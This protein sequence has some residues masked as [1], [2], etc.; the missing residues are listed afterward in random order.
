[1]EEHKEVATHAQSYYSRGR[2]GQDNNTVYAG[3]AIL[4][5]LVLGLGAFTF[6]ELSNI[7][8]QLSKSSD[9]ESR[10]KMLERNAITATPQPA[11][12]TPTAS[13]PTQPVENII[14][15]YDSSCKTCADA[16]SDVEAV[17]AQSIANGL[18]FTAID[19]SG[20]VVGMTASGFK[21]L[22]AVYFSDANAKNP[23]IS[24]L[25][26]QLQN[27][28]LGNAVQGGYEVPYVLIFQNSDHE[29]LTPSCAVAKKA[30]LYEFSDFQCPYCKQ[31][32]PELDALKKAFGQ[33]LDFTF[34]HFPLNEIHPDANFAALASECA[35]DQNK[36]DAYHDILYGDQANLSKEALV[37]Y[38][39]KAGLNAN[40][41]KS[42]LDTAPARKQAIIDRDYREGLITYQIAGTPTLVLDCKYVFG[43][44]SAAE[45]QKTICGLR[46]DACPAV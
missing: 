35:R 10:V 36:F 45:L 29:L 34:K 14:V 4:A 28:S 15:Y 41:F 18:K 30:T 46:P 6:S 37:G 5:I 31:L 24:Q 12:L 22:P 23:Q 27:Q 19:V 32:K 43:G 1:M 9:L 13:A 44:N 7:R 17:N 26:T 40:A 39:S 38:A 3:L 21:N 2:G 8:G 25:L 42:C 16:P 20:K 33:K 11:D